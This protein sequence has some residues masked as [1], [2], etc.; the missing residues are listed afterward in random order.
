MN[1]WLRKRR[2]EKNVKDHLGRVQCITI[3]LIPSLFL[4]G[5]VIS[6]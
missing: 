3:I 4:F 1:A 6:L 5:G 2:D